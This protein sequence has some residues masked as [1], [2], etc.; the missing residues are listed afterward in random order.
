MLRILCMMQ[1]V[2]TNNCNTTTYEVLMRGKVI[3]QSKHYYIADFS[4]DAERL[5]I[6]DAI[7]ERISVSKKNCEV[8][9][10]R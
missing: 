10:G 6:K 3:E 2:A 8:L 1:M 9:R 5:N 4:K 7:M